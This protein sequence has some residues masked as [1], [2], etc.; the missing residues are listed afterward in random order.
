MDQLYDEQMTTIAQ[1]EQQ[2]FRKNNEQSWLLTSSSTRSQ[3]LDQLQVMSSQEEKNYIKCDYFEKLTDP[4]NTTAVD[5]WCRYKMVEWCYEVIDFV[6]LSRETAFV[7]I[8]YLDRFLSTCS[9]R[10]RQVLES[11]KEYQ[12]AAMTC[13]FIAIKICEPKMIDTTLLV[14]LSRGSYDSQDFKN[15]EFDILVGL[16]WYLNDPTP[17]SFIA[18]YLALLPLH[19]SSVTSQHEVIYEHAKFQVE[20]ALVDYEMMN[21]P[22][23]SIALAAL[24]NSLNYV[25]TTNGAQYEGL[26]MI[27]HL[28]EMS[29]KS[30]LLSKICKLSFG[31][32]RL[33]NNSKIAMRRRSY[34]NSLHQ[35][36]PF[37]RGYDSTTRIL[38]VKETSPNCVLH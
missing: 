21:N 30:T 19:E 32:E 2:Q 27:R 23:S 34:P 16:K 13:L 22:P 14:Q 1:G 29:K 11:R 3:I 26:R 9:E 37:A 20:L 6:N 24:S 4:N 38:S 15:M 7:A 25:F 33:H 35:S 17:M 31:L 10:A 28:E 5:A 8:S 12:L 36:Q 18:Y